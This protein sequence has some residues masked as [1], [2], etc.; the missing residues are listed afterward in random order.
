V[1]WAAFTPADWE[2][3]PR[4]AKAEGVAPLMYDQTNYRSLSSKKNAVE[5]AYDQITVYI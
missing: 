3:L 4:M 2:R 5:L 1:D